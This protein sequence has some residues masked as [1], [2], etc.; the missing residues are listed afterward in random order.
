[1]LSKLVS[2]VV[3]LQVV[4]AYNATTNITGAK[5]VTTVTNITANTSVNITN[6][7]GV[8]HTVAPPPIPKVKRSVPTAVFHGLNDNCSLNAE[9]VRILGEETKAH[10]ECIEVGS[11]RR[12]TW[13]RSLGSQAAEACAAI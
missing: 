13:W 8:N 7:T 12:S 9:M 2:L 6:T 5:N 10:V 1:M 3:L 11:G 4:I